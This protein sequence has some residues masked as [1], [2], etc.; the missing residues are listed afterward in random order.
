MIYL[1]KKVESIAMGNKVL[2]KI[3]IAG[4]F[5]LSGCETTKYFHKDESF[6]QEKLEKQNWRKIAILPFTGNP[7]FRRVS[8]E[9]FSFHIHK[10]QHF[11]IIG[12]AIAEIELKKKGIELSDT[13]VEQKEAQKAGRLLG[14]DA[15]I[16]GSITIKITVMQGHREVAGVSLID[17]STGRI[18]ATAIQSVWFTFPDIFKLSEDKIFTSATERVANDILSMLHELT[19]EKQDSPQKEIVPGQE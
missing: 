8:A 4:F 11:E 2:F 13:E 10:Q 5:L 19:A 3:V 7:A 1:M 14:A 6:T 15:V 18:V 9:M 16:V 12:P 17:I